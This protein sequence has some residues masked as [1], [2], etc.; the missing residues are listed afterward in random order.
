[1]ASNKKTSEE[2]DAAALGGTELIRAV[3]SSAN[4]KLTP[5]QLR[6]FICVRGTF[7]PGV[8]INGSATGIT[9]SNQEGTYT[10]I[11][12]R[13]LFYVFLVLTS[14]GAGTGLA[15]ITGLPFTNNDGDDVPIAC[16][17]ANMGAN[18]DAFAAQV[19]AGGTTITP[20]SVLNGGVTQ[21][22]EVEVT[23]TANMLFSGQ[24]AT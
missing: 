16:R 3:Q 10:K 14:N 13:V 1:M 18:V 15:A 9:F 19:E 2:A 8:T 6:S 24:Y 22:T 21:C 7:T 11:D 20:F 5:T 23:D 12:D 17:P 4:V